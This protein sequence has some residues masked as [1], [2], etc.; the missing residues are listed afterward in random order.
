MQTLNVSHNYEIQKPE[1]KE[2][3]KTIFSFCDR[4][5]EDEYEREEYIGKN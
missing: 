3:V 4:V 5:E 2:E 1:K